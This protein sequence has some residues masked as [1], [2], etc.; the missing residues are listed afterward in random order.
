MTTIKVTYFCE[1]YLERRLAALEE[2][3]SQVISVTWQGVPYSRFVVVY[4]ECENANK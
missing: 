3:G 2:R 1:Q 4:R